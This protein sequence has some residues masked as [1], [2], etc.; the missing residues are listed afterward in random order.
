ML[1]LPVGLFK[2]LKKACCDGRMGAPTHQLGD[3]ESERAGGDF[4]PNDSN[5]KTVMTED[6]AVD[7]GMCRATAAPSILMILP[8]GDTRLDGFDDKINIDVRRRHDGTRDPKPAARTRCS[9]PSSRE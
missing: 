2:Q 3:R 4:R 1:I 9:C 5:P 8:K 7:L 6:G